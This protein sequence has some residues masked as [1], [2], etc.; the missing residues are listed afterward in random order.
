[1]ECEPAN[2]TEFQRQTIEE[3]A[4]EYHKRDRDKGGEGE[5]GCPGATCPGVQRLIGFAKCVLAWAPPDE[6]LPNGVN[7]AVVRR[8]YDW[9]VDVDGK[10]MALTA[11]D[12]GYEETG[13]TIKV[14]E[15]DSFGDDPEWIAKYRDPAVAE[16]SRKRK[17]SDA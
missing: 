5:Y 7:V 11:G 2:F 6:I 17:E 4:L 14:E 3:L 13:I 12:Q 15:L 16:A 8:G 9:T 10:V 1:M